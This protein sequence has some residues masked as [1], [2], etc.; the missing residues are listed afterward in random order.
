MEGYSGHDI[1]DMMDSECASPPARSC[2][3]AMEIDATAASLGNQEIEKAK[4]PGEGGGN[5][6]GG[7]GDAPSGVR[8]STSEGTT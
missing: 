3:G 6:D 5:G 2:S 7:G 1:L 8:A 4:V